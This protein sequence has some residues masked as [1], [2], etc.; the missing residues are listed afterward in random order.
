MR[1]SEREREREREGERER[2]REREREG[3][4]KLA[5]RPAPPGLAN[6]TATTYREIQV[7]EKGV[8][9]GW[10][11]ERRER[12]RESALKERHGNDDGGRR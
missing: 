11:R 5:E 6:R 2:E 10:S 4:Q 1:E 9:G 3:K 8:A 12:D 7:K